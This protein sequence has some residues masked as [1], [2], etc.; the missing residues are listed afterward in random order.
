MEAGLYTKR[1]VPTTILHGV[2]ALVPRIPEKSPFERHGGDGIRRSK[3]YVQRRQPDSVAYIVLCMLR[4][5]CCV[6]CV[7]YVC[8][9][10]GYFL[11]K[12]QD[13]TLGGYL[14]LMCVLCYHSTLKC[15]I[16]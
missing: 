11:F 8:T 15:K 2:A 7:S 13:S 4:C 5:V 3:E 9:L 14:L 12:I 6:V 16:L 10:G 1:G